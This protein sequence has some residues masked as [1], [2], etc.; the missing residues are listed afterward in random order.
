M[1]TELT[2]ERERLINLSVAKS[3]STMYDRCV[4]KFVAFC[5]KLGI[6]PWTCTVRLVEDWVANLSKRGLSFKSVASRISALR[7]RFKRK[8]ITTSLESDG[9]R[10]ML[11]GLKRESRSRS[12]ARCP[13]SKSHLRRLVRL[14]R[15]LGA[16]QAPRFMTMVSLAFFGFLRPSELCATPSN[17]HLRRSDIHISKSGGKCTLTFP[18]FKHSTVPAS[19]VIRDSD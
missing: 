17:H 6:S 7:H 18:S 5:D 9:L 16:T 12:T 13:V 19:V 15:R 3:T 14:A 8:G 10:L 2:A 11:K 4:G 1:F